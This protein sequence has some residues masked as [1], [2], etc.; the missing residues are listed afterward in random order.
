V[1]ELH[2]SQATIRDLDGKTLEVELP[3]LRI[4]VRE[5]PDEGLRRELSLDLVRIG[6]ASENDLV[7][8]DPKVSRHHAE[9]Q[10]EGER[11]VLRDMG[12][13]NGTRVGGT[14]V[15]EVFLEPG[16]AFTCGDS[17]I[18][19]ETR[20]TA[21]TGFT[22][23]E[24]RLGPL[25]G[26]SPPMR[27]LFGVL[28]AVAET[29][30]TVLVHGESG[31]GKELVAQALHELSGREG[32]LV[33][34]DAATT[35]PEM[36]RSDLFGHEK[37]AFTGAAKDRLGA[38]RK[39]RGGTLF[40]DEIGELDGPLQARL[41]RVLE[42]R[43]VTPLGSD[44][45]VPVDVRVVAATHRDLAAMA[46]E[47]TFRHDLYHR[48]AVVP[49]TVPPLRERPE[50]VPLLIEHLR[51]HLG[52]EVDLGEEARAALEAYP[53]P[54][55]VRELRNVLERAAALS[56]GREVAPEDLLLPAVPVDPELGAPPQEADERERIL[57]A[58][59]RHGGNKTAAARALGISLSTL[60]RRLRTYREP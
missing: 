28:R 20:R 19:V 3:T 9:L 21:R 42:S 14:Q 36:M 50:D 23:G 24:H 34:F 59:E 32:P 39:A 35:D 41:L 2:E 11:L 58:L 33:I 31:T 45:P 47:G 10:R 4:R 49:V 18:V 48:L 5:G 27:H 16:Q 6:S 37:G 46:R 57:A 44:D 12:S 26:C 29:H 38:F 43:R 53:W 54:G 7:L 51:E 22:S 1:T 40:L 13:T 15:R 56:R 17:V 8:A 55:N 52:L 25:V 30:A 60:Q